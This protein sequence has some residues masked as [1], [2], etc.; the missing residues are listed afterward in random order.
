MDRRYRIS[1]WCLIVAIALAVASPLGGYLIL[2]LSPQE[3]GFNGLEGL[4]RVILW[5]LGGV[6]VAGCIALVSLGYGIACARKWKRVLF[7][8][9]PLWLAAAYGLIVGVAQVTLW[10]DEKLGF[11][12][13]GMRDDL[14]F[15]L[16]SWLLLVSLL[17]L[18]YW[19]VA[20]VY[21]LRFRFFSWWSLPVWSA[22]LM[23]VI[24]LCA[25]IV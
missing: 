23:G 19:I 17:Y 25:W 6:I 24:L 12:P 21:G 2:V 5:A 22:A 11:I 14:A 10:A 1:L 20:A 15:L 8:V 4:A 16:G 13:Q 3:T 9:I 7:W 18:T